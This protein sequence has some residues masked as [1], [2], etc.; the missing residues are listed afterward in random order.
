MEQIKSYDD[1]K[2]AILLVGLACARMF[3]K[4]NKNLETMVP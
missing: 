3:S 2:V 4:R 1:F